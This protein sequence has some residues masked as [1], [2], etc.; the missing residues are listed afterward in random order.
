MTCFVSHTSV[1]CRNAYELSEWWKALLGYQDVDGDPNEP[2]HE[3]CMI[4]DPETGH[5]LLFIEVPEPK[6][7]KNRIHLDLVPRS[8]TRDDELVRLLALGATEVADL[9]RSGKLP[10][11]HRNQLLNRFPLLDPCFPNY[12]WCFCVSTQAVTVLKQRIVVLIANIDRNLVHRPRPGE[13]ELSNEL[14][15]AEEHIGDAATF[16]SRQPCRH[17]RICLV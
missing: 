16:C 15:I 17:E 12:H 7:V 11:R 2:G 3:E 9:L 14:V 6:A 4:L 8:G 10:R 5:R 13:R 1:D